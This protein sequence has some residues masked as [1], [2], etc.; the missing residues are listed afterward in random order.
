MCAPNEEALRYQRSLLPTLNVI[1]Q[2]KESAVFQTD[3]FHGFVKGRNCV[4]A[5]RKH[6]GYAHT[7]LMDIS[8]FFDSIYF[9]ML[10]ATVTNL[11]EKEW[12]THEDGSLAQGFAS[13]PMLANIYLMNPMKEVVEITNNMFE[14]AAVTIYADDIQISVP[15][16]SYEELNNLIHLVT[17]VFKSYGLEINK[18]KTRIRHS[19]FGNRN[20][21][22]IQVGEEN[23][24][25][26]RRLRK[27]VRAA[28]YQGN[29]PSLGGLVTATR[30]LLPKI[31]RPS[32]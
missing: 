15:E 22:G 12:V 26:N 28:R 21:L 4:T 2:R 13:S 9:D 19:K 17:T 20:I 29:G 10:P 11:I 16:T 1:L 27:K 24:F 7:V 3:L 18:R 30:L 31:L 32:D 14:D 6:I 5:A 23:L 25:A 8:S